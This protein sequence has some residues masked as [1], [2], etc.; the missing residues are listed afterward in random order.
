MPH[1]PPA[2]LKGKATESRLQNQALNNQL[3]V[4]QTFQDYYST[5]NR[6]MCLYILFRITQDFKKK[7]PS[8][9]PV[10]ALW[11]VWHLSFTTSLSSMDNS[12]MLLLRSWFTL[13]STS[14]SPVNGQSQHIPLQV[15]SYNSWVGFIQKLNV[16]TL[17]PSI[18]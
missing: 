14:G 13:L 18:D 10:G 2:R 8:L 15:C 1:F 5:A 17:G 6:H 7:S 3:L 12:H 16:K 4:T 11:D 9:V